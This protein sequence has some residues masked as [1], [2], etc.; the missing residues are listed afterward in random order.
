MET[1]MPN[2]EAARGQ[3]TFPKRKEKKK[4]GKGERASAKEKIFV[5]LLM[6]TEGRRWENH[7]QGGNGREMTGNPGFT[8]R[9]KKPR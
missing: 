7:F 3:C 2:N 5:E 1:P 6:A 9:A 8:S 4:S